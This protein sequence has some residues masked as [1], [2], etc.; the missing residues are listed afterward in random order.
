MAMAGQSDAIIYTMGIF[1][2]EDAD[3]N[4]HVLKQLAK[5]TGGEAFLP[6]SLQEVL[7]I[8]EHI[9]RDIRNQYTIAYVPS[10]ESQDGKYRKIHVTAQAQG[11]ERLHIRTRA[12]YYAVPTPQ[13]STANQSGR[14]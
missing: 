6:K 12:G 13:P 9:A 4:P 11:R 3:Q 10:N 8:C 5:A 14:P 1:D 7:P 2:E